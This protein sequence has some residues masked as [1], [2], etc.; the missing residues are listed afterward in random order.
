MRHQVLATSP[1]VYWLWWHQIKLLIAQN[2]EKNMKKNWPGT[3]NRTREDF[4]Q[5]PGTHKTH[6][7]EARRLHSL[8]QKALHICS[9]SLITTLASSHY[10]DSWVE[11]GCTLPRVFDQLH[12]FVL[13]RTLNQL[14]CMLKSVQG[15]LFLSHGLLISFFGHH[16]YSI[17]T[18]VDV[19]ILWGI[20]WRRPLIQYMRGECRQEF[21]FWKKK[22]Y[23]QISRLIII[24]HCEKYAGFENS[25][26]THW[27]LNHLR[28]V[29][30]RIMSKWNPRRTSQTSQNPIS[31]Y[32]NR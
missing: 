13:W 32:W 15:L 12:H 9:V 27:E 21:S 2:E 30:Y 5:I 24:F 28:R 25:V 19:R 31:T 17:M 20:I 29:A 8:Q 7:S 11:C 16:P 26:D 4:T 18:L 14:T 1:I 23:Q 3:G 6:T 22:H 10:S